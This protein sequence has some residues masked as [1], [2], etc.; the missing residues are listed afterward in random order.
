[1]EKSKI[2]WTD[3]TYNPVTGCYNNCPYCYAHRIA[4]L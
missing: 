3:S 2:E 4:A 1:M